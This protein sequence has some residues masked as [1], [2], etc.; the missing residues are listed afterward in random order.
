[1][2]NTVVSAEDAQGVQQ[3]PT[4]ARSARRKPIWATSA[5]RTSPRRNGRQPTRPASTRRRPPALN[6]WGLAGNWLSQAEQIT[7]QGAGRIVYRF[8]ARDLHLVLG[9]GKDGKP[10]RFR[11]SIDGAAPGRPRRVAADGSG[12]STASACTSWCAS[13]VRGRPHLQHRIP[14]SGRTGLRLHLRL[15]EHHMKNIA[16]KLA[17]PLALM[18]ALTACAA[19]PAVI[20]PPAVDEPAAPN[21]PPPPSLPAAASGACRACS[22][23]SKA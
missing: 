11:V 10:V 23:T 3:Q 15:K 1:V 19:E 12:T 13:P 16:F 22:S 18:G 9:P 8:H 21:T 20:A 5:P 14:R 6:Q 7:L 17:A 2:T 4:W